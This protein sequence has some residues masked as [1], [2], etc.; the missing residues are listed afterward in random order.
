MEAG[1]K[2]GNIPNEKEADDAHDANGDTEQ[3]RVERLP[4][5]HQYNQ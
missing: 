1:A 4:H 2:G 5:R 3:L